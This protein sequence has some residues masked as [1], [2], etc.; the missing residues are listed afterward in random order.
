[1]ESYREKVENASSWLESKIGVRPDI[2]IVLG[3][4]LGAVAD[5]I[6]PS[7]AIPYA[8]IPNWPRS[9][10]PGH[11]GRLVTGTIRGKCVVCMQGR[12]HGYEGYSQKEVT[13]PV[14]VMKAIG[15]SILFLTNASGSVNLSLE[16]GEIVCVSD[17][18]N[19]TGSNPLT[20]QDTVNG[21]KR[22]P[23]MTHVYDAG[24]GEIVKRCAESEGIR[25]KDGVYMAFAGP[26]YETPAEIRMARVM[27][28]DLVG[29]STVPEAIVANAVGIRV[30]A[31][32]CVSNY[33]AGI[34][35]ETLTEE[36]VLDSMK[37]VASRLEAILSRAVGVL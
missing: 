26:S 1:M 24:L 2:G 13:F 30:C 28:A 6:D 27:G 33:A 11:S 5:S 3:S 22:F 31:L 23:D 36:E 16:P 9:T 18:I 25:M 21:A 10:A 34:T 35:G 37:H 12:V 29:M 8:E 17:H 20:G 15:V 32:S 4:G 14:Q 7:L 19:F